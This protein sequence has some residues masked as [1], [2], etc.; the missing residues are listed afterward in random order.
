MN[1]TSTW[2]STYVRVSVISVRKRQVD[3]VS[4]D[5]SEVFKLKDKCFQVYS[6]LLSNTV[7]L[8]SPVYFEFRFLQTERGVVPYGPMNNIHPTETKSKQT[9][10]RLDVRRGKLVSFDYTLL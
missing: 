3:H 4:L 6:N 10:L 5:S 1:K 8:I 9:A 7:F 2:D